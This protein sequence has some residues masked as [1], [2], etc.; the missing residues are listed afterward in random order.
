M[1][2]TTEISYMTLS[3]IQTHDYDCYCLILAE[4]ML[5]LFKLNQLCVHGCIYSSMGF[6]HWR[7]ENQFILSIPNLD[8][9]PSLWVYIGYLSVI[10]KL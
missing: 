1:N 10:P 6:Y 5:L 2:Q 3:V 7:Q 9:Y 4:S 8:Q